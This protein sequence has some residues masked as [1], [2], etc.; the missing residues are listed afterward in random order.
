MND[1]PI[2]DSMEEM[3]ERVNHEIRESAKELQDYLLANTMPNP[4]QTEQQRAM[5][6]E[7]EASQVFD[8]LQVDLKRGI[9]CYLEYALPSEKE[10]LGRLFGKLLA[11]LQTIANE[12]VLPAFGNEDLTILDTIATRTFGEK[13]FKEAS[14]MWRLIIQFKLTSSRA[15][16]GW[17]L[18]EEMNENDEVVE[19]IYRLGLE[20]FP[21][22]AYIALF[23]ADFYLSQG[24]A[25]IAQETINKTIETLKETEGVE[26]STLDELNKKLL[27]I[28]QFIP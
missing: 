28:A 13:R 18:A 2:K 19:N 25:H 10:E 17:A 3:V 6:C 20:L 4:L 8:A 26:L 27:E 22:N 24:K 5:R 23:A 21:Y 15:W 16:V 11:I 7:H 12:N 14:C 1:L 9:E